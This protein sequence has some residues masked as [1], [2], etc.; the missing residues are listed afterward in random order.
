[1]SDFNTF[2]AHSIQ[3]YP[4]GTDP[5][6]LVNGD[7]PG[8]TTNC[9]SEYTRDIGWIICPVTTW[10]ASAMDA[11]YDILVGFLTGGAL[12][13]DRDSAMYYMW[14]LVR[15]IANIVFIIGFLIIIYSQIT[16]VGLSNYGIKRL[17]PRILIAAVLVNISYWIVALAVD[18]SNVI[19]VTLQDIF[20]RVR[21]NMPISNNV[22]I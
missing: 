12:S 2:I 13:T 8:N 20:V 10:I 16:S 14:G 7:N 5:S 15:N 21:E 3:I 22:N 4:E 19:G 17:L 1:G 6:S 18:L 11:L 9:S